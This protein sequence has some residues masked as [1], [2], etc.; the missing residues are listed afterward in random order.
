MTVETTTGPHAR[1]E[2]VPSGPLKE[3]GVHERIEL[4]IA[5]GDPAAALVEVERG[6]QRFPASSELW[7]SRGRLHAQLGDHVA[8][9]SAYEAALVLDPGNAEAT[10]YFV[11]RARAAGDHAEAVRWLTRRLSR[12]PTDADAYA[13]RALA[14]RFCDQLRAAACDAATAIVLQPESDQE[15][16]V[17]ALQSIVRA[18]LL[19]GDHAEVAL[20]ERLRERLRGMPGDP[21]AIDRR[22]DRLADVLDA[23]ERRTRP[24]ERA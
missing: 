13:R 18:Y 3:L 20:E 12:W 24:R 15:L 10:D 7:V 9:A 8:S 19:S 16:A 22:A 2:P 21:E 5:E 23:D 1:I 6:L 14:L 4:A 11:G 17:G